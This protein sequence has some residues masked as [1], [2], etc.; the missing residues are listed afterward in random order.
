MAAINPDKLGSDLPTNELASNIPRSRYGGDA[1]LSCSKRQARW[2]GRRG[3]S[4]KKDDRFSDAGS[5]FAERRVFPRFEFDAPVEL[6]DPVR[7]THI[8]GRVTEIGQLGCFAESE[9]LLTVNSVVQLRIHKAEKVFETWARIV[10]IRLGVGMGLRFIDTAP[11][12]MNLL[13]SWLNSAA[14]P[15]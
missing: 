10:Y 1:G 6:T 9:S 13:V 2:P 11:T 8:S 3:R 14:R 4:I 12:E 7:R 5:R 15:A